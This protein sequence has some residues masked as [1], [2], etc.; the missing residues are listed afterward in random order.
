MTEILLFRFT[1]ARMRHDSVIPA[2]SSAVRFQVNLRLLLGGDLEARLIGRLVHIRPNPQAGFRTGRS[3][4]LQHGFVIPERLS[5]PIG[6]NMTKQSVLNQVPLRRVGRQVRDGDRQA[7]FIRQLLEAELPQP[8]PIAIRATTVRFNQQM[9][10]VPILMLPTLNPPA[11]DGGHGELR[12]LVRHADHD[13]AFIPGD[14]IDAIRDGDAVRLAGVVAFQHVQRLPAVGL[15][16]VLEVPHQFPLLGIHR[17]H[18][19]SS[20][21]ERPTLTY[22]I[23]HLPVAF[24]VVFLVQPFAVDAQTVAQLAQQ[25]AHRVRPHAITAPLQFPTDLRR[26]FP[27]PLQ[28]RHWVARRGIVQQLAQRRQDARM[29]FSVAGRPAPAWRMRPRSP[30]RSTRWTSSRPR[31]IVGRLNPV[32]SLTHSTPPQ[33][34]CQANKPAKCRRLFS[35]SDANTRL[36]ARCSL[37]VPLRGCA[38]QVTQVQ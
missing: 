21:L 16:R 28:A 27:R 33:P 4:E 15:P 1:R 18:G 32:I 25:A 2:R 11:P 22:Q 12:R 5:R 24:R 37:A 8:T 14:I 10:L 35:S 31:R 23:P 36:M 30:S 38:R 9:A 17:N 19:K 3:N 29:F 20:P 6:F 13:K 34:H 26:R 7:E